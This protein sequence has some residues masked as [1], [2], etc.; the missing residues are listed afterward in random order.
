M[1]ELANA[2][3]LK[4]LRGFELNPVSSSRKAIARYR[5]L[6]VIALEARRQAA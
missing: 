3:D 1:I 4:G 2:G 6:C 5:D